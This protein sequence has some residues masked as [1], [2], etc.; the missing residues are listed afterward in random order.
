MAR[1]LTAGLLLALLSACSGPAPAPSSPPV[2]LSP[3]RAPA[4]PLFVQ[5]PYLNVWLCG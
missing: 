4:V 3:Y 5:T 1:G 2:A